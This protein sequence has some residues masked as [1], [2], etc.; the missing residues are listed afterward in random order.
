ME[1]KEK[2]EVFDL[3]NDGKVTKEEVDK[4]R[5]LLINF[6]NENEESVKQTYL[7]AYDRLGKKDKDNITEKDIDD[8]IKFGKIKNNS[9]KTLEEERQKLIEEK[10]KVLFEKFNKSVGGDIAKNQKI[11][12]EMIRGFTIGFV[13]GLPGLL[14]VAIKDSL[15]N[16][17]AKKMLREATKEFI[18]SGDENKMK[19]AKEIL[20]R[21]MGGIIDV[22]AI[23]QNI[24]SSGRVNDIV[25]NKEELEKV[26]TSLASF[27]KTCDKKMEEFLDKID[28]E[29]TEEL[30]KQR[31]KNEKEEEEN[32]EPVMGM[33]MFLN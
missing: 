23:F 4:V 26:S 10:N 2:L 21:K 1:N 5:E 25:K 6:A 31:E 9:V 20:N 29:E 15:D 30:Q 7:E 28:K 27:G 33:K 3:N 24:Q 32:P 18:N 11:W 17:K 16:E 19:S 12:K 8:L 14:F 22:N 13:F